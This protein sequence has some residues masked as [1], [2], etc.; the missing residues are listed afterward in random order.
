VTIF[1]RE[2]E[3]A[4]EQLDGVFGAA[5]VGIERSGSQTDAVVVV[6]E[7]GGR[8]EGGPGAL[9]ARV[10][11]AV[12]S[13]VGFVPVQVIVV[14]PSAI[15]RTSTGK[16]QYATLRCLVNEQTFVEAALFAS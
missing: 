10:E 6:V 12:V 15:P 3:E 5:A 7:A 14:P 4:V 9:A 13:A 2:I 11:G 16:V 1:P 8:F